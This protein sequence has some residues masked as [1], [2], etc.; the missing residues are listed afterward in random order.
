[1]D[2]RKKNIGFN[3]NNVAFLFHPILAFG[4]ISDA[5][6]GLQPVRF[7]AEHRQLSTERLQ[8]GHFV[9]T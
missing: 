3:G 9:F 6:L 8:A 4:N 2:K 7:G 5:M 1:M